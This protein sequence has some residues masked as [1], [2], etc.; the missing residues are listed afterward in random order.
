MEPFP[1]LFIICPLVFLAGFID[2]AAGGGG[3]IALP[4]YLAAGL[5]PHFAYGTNKFASCVGTAVSA[6]RF[7]RSGTL[8][9]RVALVS[10]VG[11]LLG[12]YGGSQLALR[13][14]DRYLKIFILCALPV[15]ALFVLCNRRF[16]EVP[17]ERAHRQNNLLLALAIG[18]TIGAYDGFFGP[19]TG[20]FLI[21]AY[22]GLMG[23][24]LPTASGNAKLV[25]LASNLASVV[26]FIPAGK[27]LFSIAIPAAVCSIAGHYLGAG[28]AIKRGTK[29]IRA[30]LVVVLVLLFLSIGKD[31]ITQIVQQAG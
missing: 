1:A 24:G 12:A 8:H 26:V 25:N 18:L 30:L 11:A 4:A 29:F 31:F 28:M 21:F 10:A 22:T 15:A 13:V 7:Y 23:F 19:G 14:D 20:T 17:P 5:P 16:G 6:G 27:V 2:A 3:L 9:L